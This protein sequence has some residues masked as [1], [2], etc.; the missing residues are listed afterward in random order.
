[1]Q[2]DED[3]DNSPLEGLMPTGWRA[4][5]PVVSRHIQDTML[6]AVRIANRTLDTPSEQAVMQLFQ[7]MIDRT[8]FQDVG[9]A[10]VH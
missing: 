2:W 1:M 8:T 3:D 6:E 9:S 5:Q 7:A 4:S 10:T